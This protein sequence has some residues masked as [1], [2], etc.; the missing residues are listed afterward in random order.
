LGQVSN[1]Q[2]VYLFLGSKSGKDETTIHLSDKFIV[3][4]KYILIGVVNNEKKYT[5]RV[6]TPYKTAMQH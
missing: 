1:Y 5:P 4:W 6:F 3:H 2:Y